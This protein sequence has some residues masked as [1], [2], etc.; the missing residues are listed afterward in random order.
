MLGLR[1]LTLDLKELT[2]G[3]RELILYEGASCRSNSTPN[4]VSISSDF[5]GLS[6][7]EYFK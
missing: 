3:L 2:L 4:A 1:K 5:I 7:L 6:L